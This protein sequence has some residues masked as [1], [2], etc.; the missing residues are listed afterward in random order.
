M[1]HWKRLTKCDELRRRHYVLPR[2]SRLLSRARYTRIQNGFRW[3]SREVNST[4][5]ILSDYILGEI[6]T[7]SRSRRRNIRIHRE[8]KRVLNEF[9]NSIVQSKTDAIA[10][11]IISR[12][13][14]HIPPLRKSPGCNSRGLVRVRTRLVGRLRSGVRVSASFHIFA[15][16][17]LLHS[18]GVYLW[19]DFSAA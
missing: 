9:T 6:G 17:M 8:V 3:N 11:T 4:T 2:P 13:Q 16:R 19:G 5:N 12:L 7:G 1:C 15:L 18:A 10:H 14:F